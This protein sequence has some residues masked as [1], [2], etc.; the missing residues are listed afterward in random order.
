MLNKRESSSL[1]PFCFEFTIGSRVMLLKNIDVSSGLVNGR[2]GVVKSVLTEPQTKLIS[3]ILVAFE[4]ISDFPLQEELIPIMKVD[5]YTRCNGSTYSFYQFPLKLC[6]SVTAHKSQ[7]QTLKKV[8]IC[9]DE[10]AFAHGSFYVALSRVKSMDDIMFFGK[11]FPE[12][13]P[14]I[15]SNEFISDFNYKIAHDL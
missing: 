12:K 4:A 9:V 7:G 6:Y 3:G 8:A 10:K 1:V 2:R 11:S 14:I 5:T 13:G 15:H